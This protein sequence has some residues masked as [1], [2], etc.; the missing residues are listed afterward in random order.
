MSLI[1]SAA[2]VLITAAAVVGLSAAP[3]PAAEEGDVTWTVRTAS[4]SYGDTRSS[5]SYAVSPGGTFEDAMVVANRGKAPVALAV[6]TADGFTADTGQLDLQ[7]KGTAATAIGSWVRAKSERVTVAPGKT[8]QIPFTVEVPANATP[9]DYVGGIVT[10]LSQ[11]DQAQGI[12]VERRLG[13]RIKLRVGGEL[14][15]ALA[16]EDLSVDFHGTANPF[17]A[18]DA[19]VHWTIHNTGNTTLSAQQAAS[20]AGPFGWFRTEASAV[21][22]PPELLPGETWQVQ[23][24]IKDVSP[25]VRL[26]ATANLTPVL[27]DPSGTS[28]ALATVKATAHAW[29]VPWPLA[30]LVIVLIAAVVALI[31]LTRRNRARRKQREDARVA[32]AVQQALREK[33]PLQE[34]K[35]AQSGIGSTSQLAR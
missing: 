2:V 20:I 34:E 8:A 10:S 30:L 15:P 16:V 7:G 13:I 31:L 11:P 27:T 4:N 17:A 26:T 12:T 29:A 1:R 23:V 18:G 5:Y 33:E 14:A 32:E 3:A 28:S 21:E 19:T 6:Y 9:G 24:K 35:S 22:A 25:A